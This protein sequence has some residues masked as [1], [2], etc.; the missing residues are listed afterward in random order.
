[1]RREQRRGYTHLGPP[2]TVLA[3][4]GRRGGETETEEQVCL[5]RAPSQA[6]HQVGWRWSSAGRGDNPGTA[7]GRCGFRGDRHRP[8]WASGKP[9]PGPVQNPGPPPSGGSAWSREQSLGL[10]AE[11]PR[12]Q[13]DLPQPRSPAALPRTGGH[14]HSLSAMSPRPWAY[15]RSRSRVTSSFSSRISLLLGSSLMT[16]LQRICLARSAYLGGRGGL[17]AVLHGG[18]GH[19]EPRLRP[20]AGASPTGSHQ[21]H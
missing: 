18:Q 13:R 3:K 4:G 11:G 17:G 8:A 5:Q 15:S 9:K 19:P 21:G 14:R 20:T 7:A 6:G 1:M 16:A 12:G 10:R 2:G